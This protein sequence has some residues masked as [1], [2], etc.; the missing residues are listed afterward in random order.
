MPPIAS[1]NTKKTGVGGKVIGTLF[2]S[3]FFFMGL[4]FEILSVKQTARNLATYFWKQAEATITASEVRPPRQDDE[5]PSFHVS[6]TY[7]AGGAQQQSRRFDRD[8]EAP[9]TTDAYRLAERFSIGKT[10]PCWVNPSDPSDAVLRRKSP[11]GALIVLFPLIFVAVGAGGLWAI[12]FWRGRQPSA[13]PDN[14]P[15]SE[16]KAPARAGRVVMVLFFGV[17]LLVGVGLGYGFF[18]RP[19]LQIVA[20]RDWI[21]V[22]CEILSSRVKTHSDSDGSTYSVD[23]VYRYL[24]QEHTYTANRHQF[25][26]GSSSGYTGKAEAVRRYPAG[27]HQTCFIDPAD[28]AEAVLDRG[29]SSVL[30]FGLIPLVFALVGGGG[31]YAALRG[32]LPGATSHAPKAA[33]A[34]SSA[35]RYDG[36]GWFPVAA[37]P[38]AASA[39]TLEPSASPRAKLIGLVFVALFWNG[40]ISVFLIN[41][42]WSGIGLFMGLFLLPFVA[43]G[44]GLIGGV[45]YQAFA[46][47]NPR[48]RIT[49]SRGVARPGDTVEISWDFTGRIDRLQHLALSL[50]GREEATYRRG[51]D[52]VTDRETF[53]RIQLL[54]TAD[55][56]A[57]RTGSTKLQIPPGAMHTFHSANNKI[58]W[59]LRLHGQIPRW[60]DV[61]EEF[62]YEIAPGGPTP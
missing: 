40:I 51:T 29:F 31:L 7:I 39:R 8:D 54:D 48:P 14:M 47:F 50:E 52:N 30:W 28:P 15:I 22:P 53:S 55:P 9:R 20:A 35:A 17:F 59:T 25:F 18:I 24:Y 19:V 26:T 38:D 36:A 49:I 56:S 57:M 34:F 60:P 42:T 21:V 32:K 61:K 37:G 58:I 44:L 62:V 27:S 6:Y 33:Y 2:F 13:E 10:A 46:L 16:K 43:V 4:S 45:V 1:Q 5:D 41:Q 12:W 11:F 23:I 3:V